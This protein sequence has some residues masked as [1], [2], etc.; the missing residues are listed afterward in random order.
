MAGIGEAS[1][2][3]AVAQAGISLSMV[4][5]AYV[6]DVR[7]APNSVSRI[8]NE[9]KST[10]GRLQEIIKDNPVTGLLLDSAVGDATRCSSECELILAQV[11]NLLVKGGW[12]RDS[13]EL[14]K[15]D[16]DTS[17]V[18]SLKWPFLKTRLETPRVELQRIKADLSLL[19]N[20]AMAR[21]SSTPLTNEYARRIPLLTKKKEEAARRAE[22]ARQ[23]ARE[24]QGDEHKTRT[25]RARGSRRRTQQSVEEDPELYQQYWEFELQRAKEQENRTIQERAAIL[26]AENDQKKK[27][28][29][30]ARREIAQ[31]AVEEYRLQQEELK[32][33]T[34]AREKQLSD[35]LLALGLSPKQIAYILAMPSLKVEHVSG[36]VTARKES[37]E[38]QRTSIIEAACV[39]VRCDI[40]AYARQTLLRYPPFCDAVRKVFTL[41]L[42]GR[43][44][45]SVR[46]STP[47]RETILT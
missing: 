34:M 39:C 31:K 18:A 12:K 28:E 42:Q 4:I 25:S 36:L 33:K 16:I 19:F 29:E 38:S 3:I 15:D 14:S 6:G 10:S 27:A 26:Q 47:G 13:T 44:T 17:V 2:I 37:T 35:E 30:D 1:A 9:I 46:P 45:K 24:S 20:V 7:D 21:K 8:G 23:K 40:L 5:I 11:G 43:T 22:E 32:A 41:K